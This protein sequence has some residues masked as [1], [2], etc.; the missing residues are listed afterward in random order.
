MSILE[1]AV[2]TI[3]GAEADILALEQ[4]LA[5]LNPSKSDEEG[6]CFGRI[7]S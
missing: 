3:S 2:F 4:W 6:I 1:D 5:S 7:F